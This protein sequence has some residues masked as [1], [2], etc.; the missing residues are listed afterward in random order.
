[1]TR[2]VIGRKR[3]V[4]MPHKGNKFAVCPT[5]L[6]FEGC[7]VALLVPD[8]IPPHEMAREY[9]T[10]MKELFQRANRPTLRELH[11]ISLELIDGNGISD[12][13]TKPENN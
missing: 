5:G 8:G 10:A 9:I 1:M 4:Q 12:K 2:R 3:P 6:I 7:K 11:E 13:I